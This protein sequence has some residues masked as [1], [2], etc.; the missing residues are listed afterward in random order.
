M[1]LKELINTISTNMSILL[2]FLYNRHCICHL[3]MEL[4]TYFIILF[5]NIKG[6]PDAKNEVD[7]MML[8]M[9]CF[10]VFMMLGM[11]GMLGCNR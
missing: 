7:V 2:Y 10:Y 11:L 4:Y 8:G 3:L 9:L 6:K 5:S 1:F